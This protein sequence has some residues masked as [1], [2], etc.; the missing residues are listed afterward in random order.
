MERA[1]EEASDSVSQWR[2]EQL[3][4]RGLDGVEPEG[5][6]ALLC[7][8][9]M[10]AAEFRF[11]EAR[12][13][14]R[15]AAG[16]DVD[17]LIVAGLVSKKGDKIFMLSAEDRRRKEALK[18]EE[19]VMDLFGEVP[20]K[21]RRSKAEVLQ[22]HPNDPTFRTT[23]DACHAL[24]LRYLEAGQ[25][26]AGIGSLVPWCGNKAGAPSQTWPA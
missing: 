11:N 10:G 6:F 3:A 15:D 26:S 1:I 16:M 24:A 7:W 9:V 12:L 22:V 2:I 14:G 25:G 8:D 4:E 21:K 20:R 18:R 23:I 17:R 19:I 13:L 5:R